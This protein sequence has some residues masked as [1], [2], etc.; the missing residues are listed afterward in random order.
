MVVQAVDCTSNGRIK[1]DLEQ[2]LKSFLYSK[3][4][5]RPMV[6]VTMSKA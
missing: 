3:T 2:M 4:K 1:S 5:R 6:F